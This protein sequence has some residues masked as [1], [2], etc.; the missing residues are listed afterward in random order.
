[1]GNRSLFLLCLLVGVFS[2]QLVWSQLAAP[3]DLEVQAYDSHF[4]LRWAPNA[5]PTLRNYKI[6]ESRAN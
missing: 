1:M 2:P 3:T 4:E 6:C 5:E